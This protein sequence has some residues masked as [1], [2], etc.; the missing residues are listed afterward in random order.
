MGPRKNK[1]WIL[2][3]TN[4]TIFFSN[5]SYT[6]RTNIMWNNQKQLRWMCYWFL[7]KVTFKGKVLTQ[8]LVNLTVLLRFSSIILLYKLKSLF[9]SLSTNL[10]N[11]YLSIDYGGIYV[12]VCNFK[13]ECV[14]FIVSSSNIK[15]HLI[16]KY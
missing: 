9:F 16:N 15:K 10:H 8:L 13:V 6:F 5:F 1:C 7:S 11:T 2:K 4:L 14:V 3:R 12:R